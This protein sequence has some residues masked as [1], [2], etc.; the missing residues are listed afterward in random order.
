MHEIERFQN[1]EKVLKEELAAETIAPQHLEEELEVLEAVAKIISD[2]Q[3]HTD[4]NLYIE[5]LS[6][7]VDAK[8]HKINDL[9]SEWYA[10]HFLLISLDYLLTKNSTQR[11]WVVYGLCMREEVPIS[12]RPFLACM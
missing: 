5:Q 8:W 12:G 1:Q 2:N 9:E 6:E 3:V 11:V 4:S 7:Q 10:I